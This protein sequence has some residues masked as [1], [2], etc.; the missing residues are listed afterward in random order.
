VRQVFTF[1]KRKTISVDIEILD[2]IKG[3]K[4]DVLSVLSFGILV[5]R[6]ADHADRVQPLTNLAK[7]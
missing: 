2:H 1:S 4:A 7:Q 5:A 3:Q 6:S